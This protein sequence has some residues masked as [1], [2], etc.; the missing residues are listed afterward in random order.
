MA[1]VLFL[2]IISYLIYRL[3]FELIIPV[4]KTSSTMKRQ[5]KQRQGSPQDRPAGQES[6]SQQTT[7]PGKPKAKVGEYIDFEEI[8]N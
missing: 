3:V 7:R 5:F 4:I 8:K 1:R 6:G 2:A